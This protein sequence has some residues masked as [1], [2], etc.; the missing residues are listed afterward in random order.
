MRSR[1]WIIAAGF[2]AISASVA[3]ALTIQLN[4]TYDT[5]NF[6]TPAE[7]QRR[8]ALEAAASFFERILVDSLSAITPGGSNS[9]SVNFTHPGTGNSQSVSN[10]TIP[11]NTVVVYAGGRSLPG[12]TIAEGGFGGYTSSGNPTW[13]NTIKNRGQ[14]GET[15][16]PTATEVAPWGGFVSFDSGAPWNFNHQA[17]PVANKNDLFS[18]AVH[19]LAHVFGIGGSDSWFNRITGTSFTGPA[20]TSVYGGSVPVTEDG[21]H[22]ANATMSQIYLMPI[23]QEASLDPSIVRGTRK[24]LTELDIAGLDDIGWDIAPRV[25][26]G[27]YNDDGKVSAADYSVWRD[28]LGSTTDLRAD[29]DWDGIVDQHDYDYWHLNF[30]TSMGSGMSGFAAAAT[31][32]T[33]VPEPASAGLAVAGMFVLWIQWM[34][35]RRS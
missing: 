19:E 34:R 6:F 3:P 25:L 10:P 11:A 2:V 1:Y 20:T 23:N 32:G 15:T 24:K 12:S 27:D 7:P 16:G 29:G 5:A 9:W 35:R 28:S 31:D 18:V 14:A 30:G 22:W 8:A 21:D 33:N 13:L 4:Y 17:G 26:V